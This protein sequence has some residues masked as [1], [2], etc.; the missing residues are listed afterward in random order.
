MAI[1]GVEREEEEDGDQAGLFPVWSCLVLCE[2]DVV[3]FFT[4][5]WIRI[6]DWL[7]FAAPMKV[8]L[9]SRETR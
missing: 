2:D 3:F 6:I 9:F 7:G 4:D 1:Q 5:Y 8:H